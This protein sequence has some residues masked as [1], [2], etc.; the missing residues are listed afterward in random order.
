MTKQEAAEILGIPVTATA[1]EVRRRYQEVFSD[2]Q[3]R[4]TNAPTA[5]LRKTYQGSLRDFQLACEVLAPGVIADSG[6]EDLPT[7]QPSAPVVQPPRTTAQASR[8]PSHPPPV[9]EPGTSGGLPKSTIILSVILTVLVAAIASTVVND[10]GKPT[11]VAGGQWVPPTVPASR[12]FLLIYADAPCRVEVNGEEKGQAGEGGPLKVGAELGQNVVKATSL[13]AGGAWQKVVEVKG[14]GQVVVNVELA[15]DIAERK[16]AAAQAV[17]AQRQHA[18]AAQQL[19]LAQQ[20]GYWTDPSTGLMWAMTDNGSDVDWKEADSYC[21][22]FGVGGY[23]D[24]RLAKIGELEGL[25]DASRGVD[26][27]I[28]WP[29]T[30]T[31]CCPWSSSIDVTSSEWAVSFFDFRVGKRYR[32]PLDLAHYTPRALCVRRSGG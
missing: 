5:Q 1:E 12:A 16:Q 2:F 20:R 10:R 24:W 17:A 30:V 28:K 4:L 31:A 18:I 11:P 6:V 7:A 19:E 23:S 32:S 9:P 14:F 21:R 13:D 29:L 26:Y 22:A 3:I 8:R 27:R 25:Y 15:K